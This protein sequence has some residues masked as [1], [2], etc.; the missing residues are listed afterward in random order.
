MINAALLL[1]SVGL[2]CASLLVM[3]V[4]WSAT[5]LDEPPLAFETADAGPWTGSGFLA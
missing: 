3:F 5:D 1:A 4:W 2:T